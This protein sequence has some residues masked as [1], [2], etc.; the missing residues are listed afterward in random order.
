MKHTCHSKGCP[1]SHINTLCMLLWRQRRR[2][3]SH[4]NGH[5]GAECHPTIH[6]PRH[7]VL[8]AIRPFELGRIVRLREAGWSDR[9]AAAYV[10]HNV[11]GVSLFSAVIY[12]IFTHTRS[13][14]SG[15]PRSTYEDQDRRTVRATVAAS[16]EEI[17]HMLHCCI[18]R[19]IG[20]RLLASG[21]RPRVPLAR[22]P[23]TPRH[24][25]ARL[26]WCRETVD[27]RVQWLSAVFSDESKFCL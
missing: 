6:C 2:V 18:T 20:N 4:A 24:R 12:G 3:I 21:L 11:G 15:R 10:G 27:W 26:L 19:T 8:I 23:L 17:R 25:Q 16:K 1:N 7:L 9:R 14:A 5:K 13:P 22:L